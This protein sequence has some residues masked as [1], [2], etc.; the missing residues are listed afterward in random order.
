MAIQLAG[1]R[2][3]N[4]FVLVSVGGNVGAEG[5]V[6][7]DAKVVM[8]VLTDGS[9]SFLFCRR[10]NF[11]LANFFPLKFSSFSY[12]VGSAVGVVGLS[13][14]FSDFREFFWVCFQF[15]R[16]FLSFFFFA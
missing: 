16:I 11:R 3:V 1:C 4:S 7:V 6:D 2:V 15:S 14:K 8:Y 13:K 5:E 10:W 12:L 9:I